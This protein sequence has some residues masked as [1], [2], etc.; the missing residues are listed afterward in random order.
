MWEYVQQ[1]VV[2]STKEVGG[3]VR[4]ANENP[5][6]E[7]WN[8]EVKA[9]LER[10]EATWKDMLGLKDEIVKEKNYI[11]FDKVEKRNVVAE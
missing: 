10:K 7:W 8:G 2:E 6:S 3:S 9:A 1:G 4:V 11:E 5:S